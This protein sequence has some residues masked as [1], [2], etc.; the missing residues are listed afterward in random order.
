MGDEND[1][2]CPVAHNSPMVPQAQKIASCEKKEENS[3][4]G[5]GCPMADKT[6]LSKP[7]AQPREGQKLNFDSTPRPSNIPKSGT[8]G[9][10]TYPSPQRF[11][12]ALK[13]KGW[14]MEEE[15]IPSVVSIHNTVNEQCWRKIMEYESLHKQ[16]CPN[17]KLL[18]FRGRPGDFTPK[19]RMLSWIGYSLPFD[20]HDW[21]IDRCGQE[22]EYVIDFYQ[23]ESR[24]NAAV[25]IHLDVRPKLSLG[26]ISDRFRM[27]YRR[28][29]TPKS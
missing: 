6:D 15:A 7:D 25:A 5:C 16:T 8:D 27:Q 4:K 9:T 2:K 12:N 28:Y 14:R 19:A 21:V 10:W 3:E 29:R 18:K 11:Y 23:G 20:R 26:G 13:K 24:T 22:V 1:S 17:P